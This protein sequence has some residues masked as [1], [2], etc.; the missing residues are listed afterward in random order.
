MNDPPTPAR[1]TY[2]HG[3]LRNALVQAGIDLADAG[4]PEAV[5]VRAAAR[6]VGV[7]PTAAYRHFTDAD[8]L[9]HAVRTC[10]LDMLVEAVVEDVDRLGGPS[11]DPAVDAV[12]KLAAMG[13]AYVRNGLEHPGL[14]RASFGSGELGMPRGEEARQGAFGALNA[15]LDTLVTVG[16]LDPAR[17]PTAT[18]DAW[19]AVHGFVHLVIDG[20]LADLPDEALHVARE[21]VL[22]MTIRGLCRTDSPLFARLDE[23]LAAPAASTDSA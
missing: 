4:G 17:R 23:I 14:F 21:S 11:P 10:A 16:F 7:T 20:P 19:A 12:R 9:M 18:V 3:D 2:H 5:G 15:V 1:S 8:D 22:E 6:Q 13:R